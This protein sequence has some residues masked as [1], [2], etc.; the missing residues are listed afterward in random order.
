MAEL[1]AVI[2]LEVHA[3]LLTRSKMFCGCRAEYMGLP[4]N[5][6]TCPTCLG[7]PGALP[8]INGR[9]VEM[10]IRT[11]LAL[12][13]RIPE[14]SKFD[15]K[16]YF[17]P[18]LP[19]G[20]QISQYDLPLSLGGHLEFEVDGERRSCGITRVHLEEDAGTLH[21]AGEIHTA[22]FSLVDLNR[23]G[24]PLM[25]IVGEPDLRSP[26]EAPQYLRALRQLLLH[27]GVNDGNME[28]GSLRCDANISLRPRGR[29]ELGVKVEVK[30]MNSFRSIEA[31]LECEVRRQTAVIE[32]GETVRQETRGWSEVEQSTVSQR[33]KEEAQDYRYFPEPDLPPLR[34]SR[35]LVERLRASLPEPPLR[36]R[37]RL[38]D[39]HQ[40]G[41]EQAAL[42]TERPQDVAYFEAM[43]AAGAP[44]RAAANWQLGPLQALCKEAKL[45]LEHSPIPPAELAELVRMVDAGEVSGTSGREVLAEAFAEA[46]S[47][48]NLIK[49]RGLTQ[50][51]DAAQMEEWVG[52]AIRQLPKAASDFQAGNDRA[53][54][55][56]V[57]AV[58]KASGGVANPDL[59]SRL[60]RERLGRGGG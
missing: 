15:R 57:G 13:C 32:S 60:L 28:Q 14:F 29:R 35:E 23:A 58:R 8:V 5:S 33:S 46:R 26:S 49:E 6:N 30:N 44:P 4:P 18:D 21:H 9:A 16:N 53:L 51:S 40:L 50:V 59:A 1:E 22:K 17:Y 25:E 55:P 20:Y 43:V 34:V 42:I 3:Q 37:D 52:A 7:L 39:R 56:L 38:R 27:L 31:A 24:V 45:D 54:G 19:K 47:P 12:G 10:M 41:E 11:A 48:V 36:L 2:G